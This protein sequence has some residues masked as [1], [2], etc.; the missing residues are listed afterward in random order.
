MPSAITDAASG[1]AQISPK[2]ETRRRGYFTTR[3]SGRRGWSCVCLEGDGGSLAALRSISSHNALRSALSIPLSFIRTS[4][5]TMDSSS[6]DS[7]LLHA[8]R[9]LRHSSS[10]SNTDCNCSSECDTAFFP[11]IRPARSVCDD[12]FGPHRETKIARGTRVPEHDFSEF[13]AGNR[14]S[15][16]H[17]ATAPMLHYDSVMGETSDVQRLIQPAKR[18]AL[19]RKNVRYG[20]RRQS[21]SH[22]KARTGTHATPLIR[23]TIRPIPSP[24]QH[25]N[26]APEAVRMTFKT[27]HPA[28]RRGCGLRQILPV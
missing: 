13:L 16:E 11:S 10:V 20:Q 12:P 7:R 1:R 3:S 26:T 2:S 19:A 14:S 15:D 23:T 24:W 9:A 28:T 18:S 5:M 22:V 4:R 17:R 27:R 6:A 21:R 25:S 8:L